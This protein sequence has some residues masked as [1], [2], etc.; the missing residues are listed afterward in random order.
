[1]HGGGSKRRA[2]PPLPT[3]PLDSS[4][5]NSGYHSSISVGLVEQIH[6]QFVFLI[7]DWEQRFTCSVREEKFMF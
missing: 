3:I 6:R 2:A 7:L 4:R 5:R 1:M